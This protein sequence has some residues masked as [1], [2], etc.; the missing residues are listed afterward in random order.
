MFRLTEIDYILSTDNTKVIPIPTAIVGSFRFDALHSSQRRGRQALELCED[1]PSVDTRGSI[2][3][4]CRLVVWRR[5]VKFRP[6]RQ[7]TI[8][9][10]RRAFF[11]VDFSDRFRY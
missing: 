6:R 9:D 7:E 5:K 10:G 3:R 11:L 4:R 8:I 2:D 1:C